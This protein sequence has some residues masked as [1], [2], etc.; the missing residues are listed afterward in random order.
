LRGSG[1]IKRK[2]AIT[3]YSKLQFVGMKASLVVY[4]FTEI[5][6][7]SKLKIVKYG[8]VIRCPKIPGTELWSLKILRIKDLNSVPLRK[9]VI[10]QLH[11][12]GRLL[13]IAHGNFLV[14]NKV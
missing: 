4:D 13:Q 1:D 11:V 10:L 3:F 9:V 6:K 12:E 8:Y 5:H 7:K 14:C 2:S